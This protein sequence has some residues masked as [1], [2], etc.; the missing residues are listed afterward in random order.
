MAT[1][2]NFFAKETVARGDETLDGGFLLLDVLLD[3]DILSAVISCFSWYRSSV[4]L[5]RARILSIRPRFV[6]HTW[7]ENFVFF[8]MHD[9]IA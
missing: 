1:L 5:Q 2:L 9:H 3:F 7:F 4:N 8:P 6:E